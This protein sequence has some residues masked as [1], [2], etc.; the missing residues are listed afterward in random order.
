MEEQI[1]PIDLEALDWYLDSDHAPDDCM[2]LSDLDGFLTGIVIGPELIQPDEWMPI[3]WGDEEPKFDSSAQRQMV[4]DTILGRYAEITVCFDWDPKDFQPIFLTNPSGEV[5]VGD[6]AAGFLDAVEMRRMAWEPLFK[7]QRAK[8]LLEPLV[9]LGADKEFDPGD[10]R[11]EFYRSKPEV[12]STCAAGIFNFWK[13]YH[14]RRKPQ[15]RRQ[16]RPR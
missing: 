13:D 12:I 1:T 6:W 4:F 2:G 10:R 8:I 11:E 9:I 15:P 5:I 14:K 16:L 3:I 7:H